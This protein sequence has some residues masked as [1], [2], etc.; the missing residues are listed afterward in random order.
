MPAVPQM[1]PADA[2]TPSAG[3]VTTYVCSC[4]PG[5]QIGPPPA[6]V[7]EIELVE[8][9]LVELPVVACRPAPP[10][11]LVAATEEAVVLPLP[12][13]PATAADD[14]STSTSGLHADAARSEAATRTG[15][16]G[17]RRVTMTS[18]RRIDWSP[19]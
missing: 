3:I 17:P 10:C 2:G 7:V 5:P 19:M 16:V 9:E 1:S 18:V 8:I 13:L 15:P 14:A 12:P 11:P 4:L 6:P